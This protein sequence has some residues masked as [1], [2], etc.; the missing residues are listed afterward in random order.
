MDVVLASGGLTRAMIMRELPRIRRGAHLLNPKV[1]VMRATSVRI[2][3]PEDKLLIEA[4]GN[5][6]GHTPVHFR[7]IPGALRVVV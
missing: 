2:S 5:V 6:R 3:T 1:R 7:I 4:D